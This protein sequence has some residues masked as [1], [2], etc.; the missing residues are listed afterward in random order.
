VAGSVLHAAGCGD[1]VFD[2]RVRAFDATLSLARDRAALRQARERL[3]RARATAPLYDADAFARDFEALISM[4]AR[5][6]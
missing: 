3:D 6:R 2:D 5:G 4:A 1:W